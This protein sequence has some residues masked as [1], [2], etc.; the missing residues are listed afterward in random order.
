MKIKMFFLLLL[1][2]SGYLT[3]QN[4]EQYSKFI[5]QGDSLYNLKKY[6]NS[7]IAYSTAFKVNNWKGY[8]ND[9][10]NTACACALSDFS[11]TAFHHLYKIAFIGKYKKYEH[12]INDSDLFS[13][14]KDNRWKIVIQQVK[15]NKDT[16]EKFLNKP[17]CK[18][19]DTIFRDDQDDRKKI[20]EFIF[21]YGDNSP[22]LRFLY[23]KIEEKDIIN[24]HKV[25]KIIDKYGWLGIDEIGSEG[26]TTLFLV[27]QHSNQSTQEKYL[28]ILK[29]AVKNK[30]ADP[31]QLA[32]LEDRL[33]IEKGGKQVYGSQIGGTKGN[34][35]LFPLEDPDNVDKRRLEVGLS[36][37]AEYL[38]LWQLK[39]D[40]LEYK[41]NNP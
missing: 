20:D 37:L 33:S 6:E 4:L 35:Y 13:L 38:M 12:I 29:D 1:C 14:H 11:D 15:N 31:S 41:K 25:S 28:P 18:T 24:T 39:W 40:L 2:N 3:S 34:Y 36:P 22:E 8:L 7:C 21:K 5:R 16:A 30:K 17:I 19:L 23:S 32:L 10:Y 9:R 27:I 26:N